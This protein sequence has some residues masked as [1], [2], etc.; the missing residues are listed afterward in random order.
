M[1][2]FNIKSDD[3]GFWSE[4]NTRGYSHSYSYSDSTSG[5]SWTPGEGT[6]YRYSSTE[7]VTSGENADIGNDVRR[8]ARTIFT[9]EITD[10]ITVLRNCGALR[11]RADCFWCLRELWDLLAKPS[12]RDLT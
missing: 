1:S 5:Q 2:T 12:P 6:T 10:L 3:D 11:T 4:G 9:D 7:G 8:I